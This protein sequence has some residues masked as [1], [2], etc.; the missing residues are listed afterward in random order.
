MFIRSSL[1]EAMKKS[2]EEKDEK[3]AN[4]KINEFS[5]S[6]RKN[7]DNKRCTCDRLAINSIEATQREIDRVQR[8]K[9]EANQTAQPQ[10]KQQ[11]RITT[12]RTSTVNSQHERS[13]EER[14]R[15]SE[16]KREKI[17]RRRW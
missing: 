7:D 15:T 5:K 9:V 14:T 17:V 10:Q 3:T 1:L 16:M 6:I 12:I 13:N 4:I 2:N 8:E 11:C